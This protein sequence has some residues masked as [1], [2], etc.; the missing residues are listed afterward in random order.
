LTTNTI[1]G[2]KKRMYKRGSFPGMEPNK[3]L[4]FGGMKY[5]AGKPPV[6]KADPKKAPDYT[7]RPS[8]VDKTAQEATAR[9]GMSREQK[10][11]MPQGSS[12]KDQRNNLKPRTESRPVTAA[13]TTSGKPG[14]G[15][16]LNQGTP[17]PKPAEKATATKKEGEKGTYA[18]AKKRNPN[19]DKL[20]AER[21]KYDK[22]SAE[23]KKVQMQINDAYYGTGE[24][25]KSMEK[26][27]IKAPKTIAAKTN[28][29]SQKSPQA[30]K[31]A[32]K[33]T[34]KAKTTP[35]QTPSGGSGMGAMQ[36][37]AALKNEINSARPVDR[38]TSA[39]AS[40]SN[41][42]A[43]DLK[44]QIKNARKAN[45]GQGQAKRQAAKISKLEERLAKLQ[46]KK[47]EPGG[48]KPAPNKGA[49]SLPKAVRNKMGFMKRGGRR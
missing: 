30:S 22:G 9:R 1:M 10:Q 15:R 21:K 40:S 29:S 27:S 32:A 2:N 43:A 25:R 31:P 34:P 46:G 42:S 44:S 3:E 49:A 47:M 4:T 14:V 20:I 33:A 24:L 13:A 6:T 41:A 37:E 16:P 38:R 17:K 8:Q 45:R 26:V 7:M 12:A 5:Q 11:N 23:Y 18:Y 35:K 48:L 28:T 39:P 19:L 36:R